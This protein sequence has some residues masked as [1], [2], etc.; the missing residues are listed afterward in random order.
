LT[1]V[2]ACKSDND[3]FMVGDTRLINHYNQPLSVLNG[4]LKVLTISKNICIGFAG[5]IS[6]QD[7]KFLTEICRIE[8]QCVCDEI[9][10]KLA[11]LHKKNCGHS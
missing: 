9:V 4:A 7:E 6:N 10:D 8:N 11:E 1:L 2:V 3:I 5:D